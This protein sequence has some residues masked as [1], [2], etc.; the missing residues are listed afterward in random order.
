MK[1]SNSEKESKHYKQETEYYKFLLT[2]AGG[3]VKNSIS[4]L[5]CLVK[6]YN[7]APAIKMITIADVPKLEKNKKK[8]AE[9]VISAFRHKTLDRYFGDLIIGVYKKSDPKEQSIWNTDSSRYTYL[10][11]EPVKN[12]LSNWM[13]DKEG[14]NTKKYIINPLIVH[15]RKSLVIYLEKNCK[16]TETTS[17]FMCRV[18]LENSKTI[19]AMLNDIDDGFIAKGVLK[20]ITPHFKFNQKLFNQKQIVG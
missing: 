17:T 7:D 2:E 11:K 1:L 10:I 13:V 6:N 19:S 5:S 18:M 8:L 15:T 12:K 3:M 4:T 14:V 20:Y 16:V 9:E